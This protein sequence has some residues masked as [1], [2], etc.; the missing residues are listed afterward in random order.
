MSCEHF[1]DGTG[2]FAKCFTEEWQVFSSTAERRFRGWQRSAA[3]AARG[4]PVKCGD[5]VVDG[6]THGCCADVPYVLTTSGC[7]NDTKVY[8]LT[9]QGCCAERYV[10]TYSSEQCD[11]SKA[12]GQSDTSQSSKFRCAADWP[13]ASTAKYWKRY[14]KLA[15]KTKHHIAWAMTPSCKLGWLVIGKESADIA[16]QSALKKCSKRAADSGEECS[17]FDLDGSA[18][19]T[20]SHPP[21][22]QLMTC[23]DQKYDPKKSGCCGGERVYSVFAEDCCDGRHTFKIASQGCCA[24]RVFTQGTHSCCGN[25][26]IYDSRTHGCCLN[27]GAEV[28]RYGTH[29]CC[30]HPAG[31]CRIPAGRPSCC[32]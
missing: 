32:D 15:G 26:E 9:T 23:G 22:S 24:G 2:L 13:P 14:C 27:K 19:N 25:E 10:Y 1:I 30:F 28:Y 6:R 7:C 16:R 3:V 29:N 21:E 4:D 18:C 11:P 12:E 8:S 31:A 5:T 20:E 17:I